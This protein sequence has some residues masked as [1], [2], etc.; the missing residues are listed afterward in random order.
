MVFVSLLA[1]AGVFSLLAPAGVLAQPFTYSEYMRQGGCID[2]SGRVLRTTGLC[3]PKRSRAQY[4]AYSNHLRS[5]G[6]MD[7]MGYVVNSRFCA[8][9]Q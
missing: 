4:D 8:N 9:S 6:C 3:D 2:R 5:V 1:A 7:S